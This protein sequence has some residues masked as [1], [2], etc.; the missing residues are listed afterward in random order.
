MSTSGFIEV[1]TKTSQRNHHAA[2]TR[3]EMT[4]NG[5]FPKDHGTAP[6]V[7]GKH[8]TVPTK[9]EVASSVRLYIAQITK[10]V[11]N[12]TISDNV[13]MLELGL[14]SVLIFDLVIAIEEKFDI[15][16]SDESLGAL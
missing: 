11:S 12:N 4:I 8:E 5:D 14:D 7:P 1:R 15:S 6:A 13:W 16:L 10:R 2:T 3:D 9:E